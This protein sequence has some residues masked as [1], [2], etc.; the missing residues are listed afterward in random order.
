LL[1]SAFLILSASS[2]SRNYFFAQANLH[3]APDS[4]AIMAGNDKWRSASR[5]ETDVAGAT[6]KEKS[7]EKFSSPGLR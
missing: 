4:A 6:A 3:F 1:Q 2:I 5:G 7:R